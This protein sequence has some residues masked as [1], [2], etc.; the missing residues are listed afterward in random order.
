MSPAFRLSL[1]AVAYACI[2]YFLFCVADTITKVLTHDFHA[3]QLLGV[4]GLIG[5]VMI[6][7]LIMIR[8]G[9]RGFITPK[10]KLYL[11]RGIAQSTGTFLVI[12]SLTTIPLADF[13]GIVFLVP[14]GTTALA[15]LFLGEKIG[16][17]RICALLIG[18]VGV[19]IITGPS[20]STGNIGYAYAL[21]AT[22]LSCSGGILVRLIGHEPVIERYALFPFLLSACVFM[23]LA[24]HDGLLPLSS[25]FDVS[26]FI[27]IPVLVTV[28]LILY[29]LAFAR[30]R[31]TAGIAPFHYTQMI[32]GTLFGFIIFHDVPTLSTIG[33]S[34]L[35]ILAGAIVIWREHI[36][37]VHIAT[38]GSENPL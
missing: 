13:Y 2:G 37:H 12:K 16:I 27:L 35:I 31:D 36:H 34:F 22:L 26:A 5:L 20:F 6:S 8:H 29:S 25:A 30:A 14:L 1:I 4:T 11:L 18:L 38:A 33:G 28:G 7:G 21:G 32:W 15:T 3:F 19:F 9:W 10:W 23:P 17:H 24:L